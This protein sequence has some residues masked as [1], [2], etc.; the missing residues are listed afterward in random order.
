VTY[1]IIASGLKYVGGRLDKKHFSIKTVKYSA[2]DNNP[3]IASQGE[4]TL[5]FL[6]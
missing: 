1:K 6:K 3:K 2:V 4:L 5:S